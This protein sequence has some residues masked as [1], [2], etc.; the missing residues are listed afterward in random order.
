MNSCC[1][2]LAAPVLIAVL[3]TCL[4]SPGVWAAGAASTPTASTASTATAALAEADERAAAEQ[5]ERDAER[6]RIDA[7]RKAVNARLAKE[8]AACYQQFVVDSCLRKARLAARQ[9]DGVLRNR[10]LQINDA[11]RRVRASDRMRTIEE[12]Q[13]QQQEKQEAGAQRAADSEA[14]AAARGDSRANERQQREQ[15]AGQRAADKTAREAA[16]AAEMA[17]RNATE[18]SRV[19][20]ARMRFEAKQ[21]KAAERRAK[22]EKDMADAAASGRKP[23]APLPPPP[24]PVDA[25][26]K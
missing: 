23:V 12:H 10:E 17:K 14:N 18:P 20:R 15:Q 19:E 25:A 2:R 13:M 24:N 6:G 8:E 3:Q 21:Q 16:H 26:S 5:R 9:E 22:H 7:Q 1:K 4:L 11:E